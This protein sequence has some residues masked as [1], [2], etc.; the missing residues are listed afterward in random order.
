TASA[1]VLSAQTTPVEI[2]MNPLP[3]GSIAGQ[4][5]RASATGEALGGVTVRVIV[6]SSIIAQVTSDDEWTYPGGGNP[7]YN[8]I[9]PSV[10]AG[11]K[12]EVQALKPG[13]TV[14]PS[15]RTVQVSSGAVTYNVNFAVSALHTVPAGL[16]F[17]SVPFD[18]SDES[19]PA[20]LG[21]P[22][23]QTLKM[24]AYDVSLGRY[25]VYPAAPADR[26]RLGMAYWL[27]LPQAQDLVSE[28]RHA[29]SPYLIPLGVGWNGI[30]NPF[31]K[32]IDFYSLR[33]RDSSGVVRSIQEAFS[34]GQ[35]RNAL[36][37]YNGFGGGY[38]NVTTLI[39]YSGYWVYA[40]QAVTLV[41]PDPS[42]GVTAADTATE[43]RPALAQPSH[44][45][46]APIE[47]WSAGMCDA[48][49][50]FGVTSEAAVTSVPK[51]PLPPGTQYVYAVFESE[52]GPRAIDARTTGNQ[53]WRL[54]V[55]AT[56]TQAPVT[57][58]WPDLSRLPQTARPILRDPESGATL[59]MRTQRDYTYKPDGAATR[60]LEI[61]VNDSPQ[62]LLAVTGATASLVAEGVSISYTLSRDAQVTAQVRNLAGRV[63]AQPIIAKPMSAGTNLTLW[64]A[65]DQ[66]GLA[67][68]A[69]KY[70][71]TITARSEDGQE[72]SALTVVNVRR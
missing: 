70:L 47:V 19:P 41:V 32:S 42:A 11:G 59:Y 43:K 36:Y 63:I 16:Q 24:A 26:L 28:G 67:V 57:V 54:T 13:F 2:K 39:P 38:L 56:N 30:G 35:V 51:P 68:P 71:I 64:D 45:W 7:R 61:E 29:T 49:C 17:I 69:G 31:T 46:L 58:T 37:A 40:S 21:T 65:R 23:G 72:T 25:A 53:L 5:Y 55:H 52:D 12:V 20:V 9:V 27:K 66:A 34:T 22:A 48:S 4:I 15:S 8:Y 33:V 60:V 18:Y 6:G 50:A 1:T 3:P 62:G 10:P 14:T 44:G